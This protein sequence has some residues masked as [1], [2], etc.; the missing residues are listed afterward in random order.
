MRSVIL[1]MNP[2]LSSS[3]DSS[4]H[5]CFKYNF[6][7]LLDPLNDHQKPGQLPDNSRSNCKSPVIEFR[8]GRGTLDPALMAHWIRFLGALVSFAQEVSLESLI[9]FLGIEKRNDGT[10]YRVIE[11][12][13]VKRIFL[14]GSQQMV[15]SQQPLPHTRFAVSLAGTGAMGSP[16]RLLDTLK[17]AK[18]L[19]DPDT[20][21]FWRLKF[22]V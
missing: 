3:A 20:Y 17:S 6:S 15:P 18:I 22:L 16:L 5:T 13:S 19:L 21:G 4:Y 2:P 8:Q 9:E 12:R 7:S 14:D 1:A 11:E 10:G